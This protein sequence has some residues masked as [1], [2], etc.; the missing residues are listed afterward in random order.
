NTLVVISGA[1]P[2]TTWQFPMAGVNFVPGQTKLIGF[3]DLDPGSGQEVIV[4]TKSNN[5]KVWGDPHVVNQSGL[6][7]QFG[8]QYLLLGIADYDKDNDVEMLL[9]DGS[10]RFLML[11]GKGN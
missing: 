6:V 1:A 11:W 4:A 10:V 7:K 9:A 5:I 8:S 3:F 2:K